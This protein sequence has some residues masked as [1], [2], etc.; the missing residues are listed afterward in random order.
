MFKKIFKNKGKDPERQEDKES[1]SPGQNSKDPVDAKVIIFP[2][3]N[4]VNPW[5][6]SNTFAKNILNFSSLSKLT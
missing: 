1:N 3:Y 5:K 6:K 2:L 4:F